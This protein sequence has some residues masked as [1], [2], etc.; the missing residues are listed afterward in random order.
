VPLRS[1]SPGIFTVSQ[2][3]S[4]QAAIRQLEPGTLDRNFTFNSAQN[5]AAPGSAFELYATGPGPLNPSPSGDV[6]FEHVIR[7]SIVQPVSLTIGGKPAQI[8]YRGS[9][10]FQ[11]WGL[12]Q[13]NAIVPDGVASGP[14]PLVLKI[15]DND[16]SQQKVT[17][18]VK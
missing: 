17:I 1:A 4:G 12:L 7:P 14:Q 10:D 3:G 9:L 6:A 15:G 11:P 2:T 16:N 18:A 13:V 8:L 5:P